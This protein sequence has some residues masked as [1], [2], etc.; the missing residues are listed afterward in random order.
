MARLL[1]P[2]YF[3]FPLYSLVVGSCGMVVVV[4]KQLGPLQRHT[5][6]W[7]HVLVRVILALH[8]SIDKVE[9]PLQNSI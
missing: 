6:E 4:G 5:L 8:H 1:Q 3:L 9:K 2:V 7:V